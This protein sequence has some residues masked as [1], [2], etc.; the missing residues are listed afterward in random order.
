MTIWKNILQ[1]VLF[2]LFDLIKLFHICIRAKLPT[3]QVHTKFMVTEIEILS[4]STC[5]KILRENE[6][7]E[8]LRK[9]FTSNFVRNVRNN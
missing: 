5:M 3:A 8:S 4:I 6:K 2:I 1:P 9:E 7:K